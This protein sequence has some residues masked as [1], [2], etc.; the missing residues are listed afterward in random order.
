MKKNAEVYILPFLIA[1]LLVSLVVSP[2]WELVAALAILSFV[3]V[4]ADSGGESKGVEEKIQVLREKHDHDIKELH[5]RIGLL[6]VK[7]GIK[8]DGR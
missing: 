2:S 7:L 5:S 8:S 4:R 1:G 3:A 6:Q